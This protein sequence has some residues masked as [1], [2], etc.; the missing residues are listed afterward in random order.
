M[1]SIIRTTRQARLTAALVATLGAVALIPAGASASTTYFG[2]SLNH[3][4]ANAG[5]TCAENGVMGP[6]L[7]THVGSYYPGFSGRAKATV[8]GTVTAFKVRAQGPTTMRFRLVKVRNIASDHKSGQAKTV[9][10][11]PKVHVNGPSQDQMDNSIYPVETFKT[12]LKVKKGYEIAI[13]TTSNT[14]E[15]C[16]DGTPG[17]LLFDPFLKLGQG[18][19]HS[20]GVDHCLMLVRAV[21]KK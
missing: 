9:A 11:G 20:D 1:S 13:D 8:N 3:E 5:S 16:S 19:R 18:F 2:S 6:G 14:A 17:Q 21:V 15:Y 7:C 12:H 4:P 10:V